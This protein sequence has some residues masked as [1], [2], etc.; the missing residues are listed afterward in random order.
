MLNNAALLLAKNYTI[1]Y[2]SIIA[3][4]SAMWQYN[5]EL[6]PLYWYAA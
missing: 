3:A 6:Q 2:L 1:S 4:D 5:S